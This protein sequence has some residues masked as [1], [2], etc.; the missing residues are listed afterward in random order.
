MNHLVDLF[1]LTTKLQIPPQPHCLAPRD[2]LVGA[3][4]RGLAASSSSWFEPRRR[5]SG[6]F[7]TALSTQQRGRMPPDLVGFIVGLIDRK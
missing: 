4:D 3:V 5:F 6:T 2:R 7:W 1:L